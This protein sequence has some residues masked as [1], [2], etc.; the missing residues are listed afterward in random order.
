MS[1]ITL[2]I[3]LSSLRAQRLLEKSTDDVSKSSERLSSGLR[4]NRASDDAAGLAIATTL[5]TDSRIFAQGIRNVNDGVSALNIA[6]GA[7]RE[8]SNVTMRQ[9]ELAEQAANGSYSLTQRRALHAEAKALTDEFNRI[10]GTTSF[11]GIN[12]LSTTQNLSLQAGAGANSSISLTLGSELA[13]TTGDGTFT[14]GLTLN[15]TT[16]YTHIPTL[17]ISMET[18]MLI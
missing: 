15:S 5:N 11:N 8:L 4:I 17:L 14:I 13:R 16:A 7:L 6:E 2:G 9:K 12:L 1:S 10:V 18:E 3:N